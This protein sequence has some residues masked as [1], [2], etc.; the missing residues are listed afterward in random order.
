MVPDFILYFKCP[1]LSALVVNDTNLERIPSLL[2]DFIPLVRVLD[3][4][5][6]K[7]LSELPEEISK[8]RCIEYLDLSSSKKV[9]RQVEGFGYTK[10]FA[11]ELYGG[12]EGISY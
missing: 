12:A 8:L 2:F 9:A 5:S 3:L 4:S 10:I 1:Q 7:K 11:D 6:N